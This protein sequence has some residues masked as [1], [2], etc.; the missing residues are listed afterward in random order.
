MNKTIFVWS[1]LSFLS[2][3]IADIDSTLYI[4]PEPNKIVE[5]SYTNCK[6]IATKP[7]QITTKFYQDTIF[8]TIAD[9]REVSSD[10]CTTVKTVL[11]D[12]RYDI[13]RTWWSNVYSFSNDNQCFYYSADN[14]PVRLIKTTNQ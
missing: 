11:S 4:C 6:L 1:W 14:S 2:V 10:V 12:L 13:I 9:D 8:I 5:Y 7:R 3:I